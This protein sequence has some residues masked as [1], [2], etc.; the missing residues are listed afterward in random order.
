[1]LSLFR[2]SIV[3]MKLS[4][5]N[6]Q[7]PVSAKDR[8]NAA[9][10]LVE[11]LTVIAIIG[12]LAAFLLPVLAQVKKHMLVTKAQL[13]VGAIATAIEGYESVYGRFPVSDAAQTAAHSD[14][15]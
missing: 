7:L 8:F 10:T 13:E 3:S 12:I 9:F 4:H 14:F 11:L 6:S 5:N 15:T 2:S 1:G